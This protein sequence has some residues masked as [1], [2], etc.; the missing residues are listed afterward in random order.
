MTR[1]SMRRLFYRVV[2]SRFRDYGCLMMLNTCIPVDLQDPQ[3][4]GT[5]QSFL[6]EP[7]YLQAVY[8]NYYPF[9]YMLP[10][11][12]MFNWCGTIGWIMNPYT[13]NYI[14]R[15]PSRPVSAVSPGTTYTTQPSRTGSSVMLPLLPE[16]NYTVEVMV[17]GGQGL[18]VLDG[19]NNTAACSESLRMAVYVP[20]ATNPSYVFKGWVQETMGSPRVM[21][22]AVLLPNGAVIM[23]NGAMVGRAGIPSYYPNFFAEMYQ[24]YLPVHQRW[25]T[26]TRS[27]ISRLYHASAALTTNGTILVA[28]S[29][30][31]RP[32]LSNISYSYSDYK[33][34]YR[35]EIFY[36]PFWFD[37]ANKPSITIAPSDMQYNTSLNVS[38]TGVNVSCSKAN[39]WPNIYLT[40]STL[41]FRQVTTYKMISQP[42][43]MLYIECRSHLPCWWPPVLSLM[44]STLTSEL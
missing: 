4:P 34:E 5:T 42:Q 30:D 8:D 16:N 14:Q 40:R 32:T 43:R 27:Q 23:L 39:E 11:G 3:N 36:P 38:Y 9:N 18:Q 44:A 17:F 15:I 6:V 20:N 2:S 24:P 19:N 35:M 10:S 7:V 31:G 1:F 13:G 37:F 28:G 21:A 29:E 41:S 25:S 22:D 26:L 33:S 12:H